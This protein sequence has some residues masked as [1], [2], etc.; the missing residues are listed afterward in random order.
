MSEIIVSQVMAAKDQVQI[1]TGKSISDDRAFSHVLL[2]Y[3]FGYEYI[4]QI[5]LVTDGTNDGGIDFLAFDDEESKLIVCQSKYTG[6]LS[7]EQIITELGKMY[8]T[9]QNFKRSHTGSYNERL[10]KALQNALDRLPDENIDNIEYYIFTTA[11]LDINGA[12]NKINNTQH[13]FPS[14]AV[15]IY[16]AEQIEKEIQKAQAQ[17]PTVKYEKI[18]LD[19]AKNYLEYESDDLIGIQCN[20]LSTSIIQLYN[21]YAGEGLFDLNIRK[22]IRNTLVDTGV[23]R[24][25]DSDRENFWFLNNGIIIA[26]TDFDIDG[27]TVKLTDFSI[28]NGGQTTTLIGTYKGTNTKEFYIPCK[29]VATKDDTRATYFYTKIAEATNSQKPIYPR[30][31]KSNAPEMVKLQTW[32][33]QEGINLEI[34]RGS[35]VKGSFKY[36]IKND[37]LGQILLSFA[38]Q[39]PG[40]SRSGKKK[41]FDTPA[42]YDKLFKVNYDKDA[43]KKAFVKDLIELDNRYAEIEKKY[44]VSGLSSIQ[45][46]VLKNGKQ[47]IFALMGVCYR[48][49]NADITESE[50]VNNPKSVATIPFVY[51]GMISNYHGDDLEKKLD[52]V[53]KALI[54][55]LADAY[56]NAF[57]NG[58]T[59]SASNFM[60]TDP[61][62]YSEIVSK[63]AHQL[64]MLVGDNLKAC[65]DIFKRP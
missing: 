19:K 33:K 2:H 54:I 11:P 30:D 43:Q 40:T 37:E 41:I 47:T 1:I 45:T 29:I 55:I 32:L 57:N 6:A 59:S 5:D 62:Y 63:F 16:T 25:L 15:T 3:I 39:Q 8:S 18:R 42:T 48:L 13:D 22:Y 46:E 36:S 50:I 61:R 26:C 20:V 14:D 17:L 51:G 23:K 65:I 44:K 49:V 56:Q 38:H 9:V 35:K 58:Q 27:D 34:K 21:K 31:L 64:G 28:V 24:T 10:K 4:D 52:Q 53:V 60:K 7:F 12:M